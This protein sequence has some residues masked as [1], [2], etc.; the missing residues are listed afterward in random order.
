METSLDT[1]VMKKSLK[2]MQEEYWE[3]TDILED[4]WD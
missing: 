2:D 4:Y 3:R 1:K